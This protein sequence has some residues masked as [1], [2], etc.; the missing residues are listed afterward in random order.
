V[1]W[2]NVW[3]HLSCALDDFGITSV[4]LE[5]KAEPSFAALLSFIIHRA[6]PIKAMSIK[7]N[8]VS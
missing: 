4:K 7:L 5:K 2:L 3:I 8:F 1:S 6:Q